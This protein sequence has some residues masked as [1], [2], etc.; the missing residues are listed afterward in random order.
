MPL[1][2]EPRASLFAHFSWQAVVWTVLAFLLGVVGAWYF[3]TARAETRKA[4]LLAR[5]QLEAERSA[6]TVGAIIEHSLTH[7][8]NIPAIVACE[9]GTA[10][11]LAR[12]GPEVQASPLTYDQRHALWL[13]DPELAAFGQRL[14]SIV[15]MNGIGINGCWLMNA[16]GDTV[17]TGVLPGDMNYTGA[18]YADRDYFQTARQGTQGRQFAVGRVTGIPGLFFVS[19][20]MREGRFLGAVGV[21][22]NIEGLAR[23]LEPDVFLTDEHGVVILSRDPGLR[24]C[25]VPGARAMGL[26]PTE[27]RNRYRQEELNTLALSF[28]LPLGQGGPVSWEGQPAPSVFALRRNLDDFL[29]VYAHRPLKAVADIE[30]DSLR[31]FALL[32]VISLLLAVCVAGGLAFVRNN[33]E[34]RRTLLGINEELVRQSRTDALTGCAN[35]RR[36]LEALAEERQR[37]ARYGQPFC[38]L[39]M[40]LDHFKLINDHRGHLAGDQA[41]RHF[42]AVVQGILRPSDLLGRLGGE[43]FCVL[44]PQTEA[45][46]AALV[47]ER[48]RAA[49]EATPVPTEQGDIPFSISA[50]VAQWRPDQDQDVQDILSRADERMYA[51]KKA[52]R[53]RVMAEDPPESA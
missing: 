26:S 23:L 22:T 52:G 24:M 36:F 19:P 53:N 48:I 4:Q 49:V 33:R 17:A 18:N 31:L 44:L 41:L 11:L 45:R 46:A 37:F 40:D 27:R 13:A 9:P 38:L 10:A 14:S 51:A 34:H 29:N 50:G 35:R 21:R 43:E 12:F 8:R 28:G 39:S 7:I 25:A 2:S 5:E 15:A 32:S 42:V 1:P 47:A 6:E 30:S 20:V 16:A 3:S